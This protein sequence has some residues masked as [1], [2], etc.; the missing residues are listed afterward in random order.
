MYL[1]LWLYYV[2]DSDAVEVVS[3]KL[4]LSVIHCSAIGCP[5][6]DLGLSAFTQAGNVHCLD[7]ECA[8]GYRLHI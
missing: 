6:S 5:L 2:S 8:S 3:D 7:T 1:M 4:A